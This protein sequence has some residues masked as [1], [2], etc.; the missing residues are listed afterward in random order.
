MPDEPQPACRVGFTDEQRAREADRSVL[1]GAIL[2]AQRPN[3]RLKPAIRAAATALAPA[4]QA[5]LAGEDSP[6]A[7]HALSYARAC[8]AEAFLQA[9]RHRHH[10]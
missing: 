2:L 10:A 8:D 6:A 5:F 7:Q 3:T 9:K 4:V 1:Y